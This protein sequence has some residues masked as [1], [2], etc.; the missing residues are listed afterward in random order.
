MTNIAEKILRAYKNW[1]IKEG[2]ML[3]LQALNTI[4]PRNT[5]DIYEGVSELKKLGHLQENDHRF[6]L[7]EKG[8][9]YI[10]SE[11]K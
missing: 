5:A 3:F 1:G 11:L 9:K 4:D 6:F 2:E 8:F 7:T 10:H